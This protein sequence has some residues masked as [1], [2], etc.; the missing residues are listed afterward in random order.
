MAYCKSFHDIYRKMTAVATS[1]K[2]RILN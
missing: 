2:I 1:V